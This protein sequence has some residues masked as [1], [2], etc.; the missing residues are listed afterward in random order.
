[1]YS[2]FFLFAF[3]SPLSVGIFLLRHNVW[4]FDFTKKKKLIDYF[5][6]E[7]TWCTLK[8]KLG[9]DFNGCASLD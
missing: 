5:D 7:I 9:Y 6:D 3:H 2:M 1:M 4:V 8:V